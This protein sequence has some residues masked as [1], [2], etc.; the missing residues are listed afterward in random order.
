MFRSSYAPCRGGTENIY[1]SWGTSA[2]APNA[3]RCGA[4]DS[5]GVFG[6]GV[7]YTLAAIED[8]T[9]NT[10]ACG[11]VSRFAQDNTVSSPFNFGNVEGAWAALE[12][13]AGPT[14]F[15]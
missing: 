10:I 4:I 9:S 14:T 8:G 3:N 15:E 6:T 2:T 12:S 5:E 1:Y 13:T 7:A 11:E